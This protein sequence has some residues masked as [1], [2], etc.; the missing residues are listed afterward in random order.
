MFFLIIYYIIIFYCIGD[1]VFNDNE[2][3]KKK[4]TKGIRKRIKILGLVQAYLLQY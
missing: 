2:A 4:D 3:I 1:C